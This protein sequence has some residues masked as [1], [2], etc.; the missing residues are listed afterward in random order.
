[1]E[2]EE[3]VEKKSLE[4]R[5]SPFEYPRSS[6]NEVSNRCP[7]RGTT[8]TE[9]DGVKDIGPGTEKRRNEKDYSGTITPVGNGIRRI[10]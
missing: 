4:S 5:L 2:E 7:S 3:C 10:M 1:M 8:G 9:E 6:S